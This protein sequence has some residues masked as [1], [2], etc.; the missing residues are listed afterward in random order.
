[1]THDATVNEL[2]SHIYEIAPEHQFFVIERDSDAVVCVG[3]S[4]PFR[5][6]GDP[7]SLPDDIDGV[8]P[9]SVEQHGAGVVPNTLCALQAI[10]VSAY[11]GRGHARVP[12]QALADAARRAGFAD[13]VAPV[14]PSWKHRVPVDPMDRY[15]TW[16]RPG[17]LPF[18]PWFRVH[19]RAG[20]SF[21]QVCENSMRITGSVKEWM[22]WTGF[23]FPGSGSFVIRGR[24]S[25]SRSISRVM[26]ASMWSRTSGRF[27]PSY[28][29]DY[30]RGIGSPAREGSRNPTGPRALPVSW[31]GCRSRPRRPRS[32]CRR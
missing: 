7:A 28:L 24:S 10:V 25:R 32:C 18:D 23:D 22:A 11:Q 14:R 26:R 4:I 3:N 5:W 30:P 21:L 6:D 19:A 29:F 15:A 1:M 8:L 16:S 17:G 31:S 2:W 13:L 9:L 20:A 27:T 12:V